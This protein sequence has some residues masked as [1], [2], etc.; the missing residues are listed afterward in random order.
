MGVL[1][2]PS[3]KKPAPIMCR[4]WGHA[5]D[6]DASYYY[7]VGYCDRCVG[8]VDGA[9]PREWLRTRIWIAR[10][11]LYE[12]LLQPVVGFFS[13]CPD[14]KHRFYRCDESVDHIPF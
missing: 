6:A 7:G 8:Q 11:C 1:H 14:C 13:R 4:L 5:I 2:Q 3:V 12:S 10:R 9:G